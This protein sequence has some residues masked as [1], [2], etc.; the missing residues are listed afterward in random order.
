MSQQPAPPASQ[1]TVETSP[2][3]VQAPQ[4]GRTIDPAQLQAQL[5]E[6]T[7]AVRKFG[8]EQRRVP[9]SLDEVVASGYISSL[10]APPSGKR[11][12]I[13]KSLQVYVANQ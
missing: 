7:Q 10:P 11:F 8:A 6:L 4:A 2:E 5:N 9:K 1:G 3:P 13:N 12:A